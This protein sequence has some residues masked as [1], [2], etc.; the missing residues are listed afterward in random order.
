LEAIKIYRT[1]EQNSKI[2]YLD[3]AINVQA[4]D[5]S[6]PLNRFERDYSQKDALWT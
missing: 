4:K 2:D 6:L 3:R 5:A 1:V